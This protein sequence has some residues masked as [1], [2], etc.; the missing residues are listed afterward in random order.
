MNQGIY[1]RDRKYNMSW[2]DSMFHTKNTKKERD[3][4]TGKPIAVNSSRGN[5]RSQENP[6]VGYDTFDVVFNREWYG[7]LGNYIS[8]TYKPKEEVKVEKEY[9]ET[10]PNTIGCY[11]VPKDGNL[12]YCNI[13]TKSQGHIADIFAGPTWNCQIQTI[14]GMNSILENYS[15]QQA[16]EILAHTWNNFKRKTELLVDIPEKDCNSLEL[17]FGPTDILFKSPYINN[18]GTPMCMYL[19]QIKTVL[20]RNNMVVDEI[21]YSKELGRYLYV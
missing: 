15:T 9:K 4:V 19:L 18:T 2:M 10:I 20:K 8:T 16:I 1:R 17:I 5:L 7:N 13:C 11:L 6:G 3:V 14:G 21:Q 12:I